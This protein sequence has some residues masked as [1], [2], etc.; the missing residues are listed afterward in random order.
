MTSYWPESTGWVKPD[1]CM[2]IAP[3][4]GLFDSCGDD[5]K[6]MP[7]LSDSGG[8]ESF[9]CVPLIDNPGDVGD[10]CDDGCA[11]G[12]GVSDD[13]DVGLGCF[14]GH[15]VQICTGDC[16]VGQGCVVQGADVAGLCAEVCDPL[17]QDCPEFFGCYAHGRDTYCEAEGVIDDGDACAFANDCLPGLMCVEGVA[18]PGCMAENCCTPFCELSDPLCGGGRVCLEYSD[19]PTPSNAD[20]GV[21]VL[22]E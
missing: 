13:C 8:W 1:E 12:P 15:C 3:C 4:A 5:Y 21:C 7:I 20:L 9:G 19:N 6:C 14:G 10:V 2:P 11:P 18:V 16:D 17:L 22:E